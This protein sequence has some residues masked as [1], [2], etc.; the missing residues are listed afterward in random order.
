MNEEIQKTFEFNR[1]LEIYKCSLLSII[2]LL[3][4][5][6]LLRTPV[7][8]NVANIQTGKVDVQQMPVVRVHSGQVTVDGT[9]SCE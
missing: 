8:F 6:I 3:L 7:P 9:V 1:A 4:L 2:A 5:A